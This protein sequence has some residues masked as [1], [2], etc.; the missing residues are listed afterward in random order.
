MNWIISADHINTEEGTSNLCQFRADPDFS[1]LLETRTE[2][3][4]AEIKKLFLT[5]MTD[6]FRLFDD[7]CELYYEGLCE[8]LDNQSGDSAFE[9]MD[10]FSNQSGCTRMDHRKIGATVWATL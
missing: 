6:E 2:E 4:N 8:N 3:E 9:P 1:F 7:D 10:W 5:R